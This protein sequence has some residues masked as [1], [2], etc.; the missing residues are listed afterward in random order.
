[1]SNLVGKPVR[2]QLMRWDEH[3]W[4]QIGPRPADRHHG[5]YRRERQHRRLPVPVV[6]ARL[7][8]RRVAPSSPGSSCR[9]EPTGSADATSSASYYDK[10]PNRAVLSKRVGSY[11]GFL[12]GT[13]LRAPAA[14]QSL[15]ASEQMID[16]LAHTANMDPIA[17]RLQ[18][19]TT[20]PNAGAGLRA[21]AGS[22]C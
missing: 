3:G 14:P 18:N 9:D 17:F 7:D 21:A 5:R 22:T 10:I 13:Y 2:V 16:A 4:D 1:M 8:V 12:K 19:M 20:D 11:H 6:P 15:F